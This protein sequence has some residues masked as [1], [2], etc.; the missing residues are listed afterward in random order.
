[1]TITNEQLDEI[2]ARAEAA[3]ITTKRGEFSHGDRW[4]MTLF[5][6]TW[7][8]D[9]D[10]RSGYTIAGYDERAEHIVASSRATEQAIGA[11]IPALVAAYRESQA[12]VARLRS[13]LVDMRDVY[14]SDW[15]HG[16]VGEKT[17]D[18]M[19]AIARE[20]LEGG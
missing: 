5:G 14:E 19:D 15:N 9:I 10:G 12:E 16:T 8:A 18:E 1:M 4:S 2:E 11:D 20:A 13:L 17:A 3:S 6:V 7:H